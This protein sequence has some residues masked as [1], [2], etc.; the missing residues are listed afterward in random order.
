MMVLMGE[1][2]GALL[3]NWVGQWPGVGRWMGRP[4]GGMGNPPYSP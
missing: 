3:Q 4:R 2:F 1:K